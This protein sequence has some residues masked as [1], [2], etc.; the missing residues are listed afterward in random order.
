MRSQGVE[1]EV[2][3]RLAPGWEVA[4]GYTF[5]TTRYL[6]DNTNG[7]AAFRTFTPRHIFQLWTTYQLPGQWNRWSVGG[8]VNVKS[9]I[10]TESAA[11][12]PVS[13]S[14]VRVSQ[15]GYAIWNARVGYRVNEHVSMGLNVNNLFDKVYY[16]RLGNADMGNAYGEPRSVMLSMRVKY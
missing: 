2:S 7:G 10:Y 11:Q 3:G 12:G 1:T 16:Q 9:G 6:K 8:G 13:G 4:G 14:S 5:N 15:G